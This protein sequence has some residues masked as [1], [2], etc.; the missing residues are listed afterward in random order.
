MSEGI[1]LEAGR[2]SPETWHIYCKLRWIGGNDL[3]LPSGEVVTVP[4]SSSALDT[5]EFAEYM[6]MVEMFAAVQGVYLD[7][8]A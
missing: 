2:Y 5:K 3:T 8:A 6:G 4:K 1:K 7:E